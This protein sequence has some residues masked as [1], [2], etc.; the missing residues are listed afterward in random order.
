MELPASGHGIFFFG[1]GKHTHAKREIEKCL[2][3]QKV[4]HSVNTLIWARETEQS[5]CEI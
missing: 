4:F 5:H 1:I 2:S 3:R